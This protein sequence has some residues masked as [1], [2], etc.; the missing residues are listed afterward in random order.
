MFQN[1]LKVA[2]R[3]LMRYKGFTFINVLGLTLGLVFALLIGLWVRDE[4]SFDQFHTKIDRL[5]QVKA[6]LSWTEGEPTTGTGI[7]GPV[8]QTLEAEVPEIEAVTKY[9]NYEQVFTVGETSTKEKGINASSGFLQIFTF[10]L[11]AGDAKTAL[12]NP[13]SIV[14]SETMARKYFG[15]TDVIG[16]TIEQNKTEALQITGVAKDVPSNS[17]IKFDWI[18]SFDAFEKANDWS[19]TWGNF[20]FQTFVLLKPNANL[21]HAEQKIK[22]VTKDKLYK[23]D[24]LLQPFGDTYLHSKFENGKVAGGR[25]EYVRLFSGI[26]LFV[27]L[28]AC[29]N[30]MNLA[31]ARAAQ[32]ARE[33]GIRKVVGAQ[34]GSLI[35]QFMGEALLISTLAMILAI[36]V[37]QLALPA[38][39]IL[40]DKKLS[41]DYNNPVF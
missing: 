32:R 3:N 30:F 31:T 36:L 22:Q 8:E 13:N 29:I 11:I 37:A 6:T 10:P 38:F 23:A 27:L 18:R 41:I 14:I 9:N 39:N 5:Y 34:R 20:S 28:L 40:F 19:K 7:P 17:S 21:A 12:N 1:Y 33:I 25:I 2:G 15:S 26:A 24:L 4:L 16:K 35:G